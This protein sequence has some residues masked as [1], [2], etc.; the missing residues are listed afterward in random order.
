MLIS[1]LSSKETLGLTST[2][3]SDTASTADSAPGHSALPQGSFP[4]LS[5]SHFFSRSSFL[6]CS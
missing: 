6:L 2:G 4:S 5:L 3:Y 1:A